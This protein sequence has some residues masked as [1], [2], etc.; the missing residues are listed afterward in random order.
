MRL[1]FAL[2]FDNKAKSD[3]M[4]YQNLLRV[5]GMDG[6]VTPKQNLHITLAFIGECTENQKQTLIDILRQL[7]SG[8]GSLRIDHLGSFRQKRSRLVWLGMANNRALTRLQKELVTALIEQGFSTESKAY[9]PH[10]TIVRRVP[11]NPQLKDIHI[12]P[13]QISVYSIAL[14]ESVY[15]ENRLVYQVIDEVIQ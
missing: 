3:L 14:M 1:F 8:C 4:T 5:H 11:G 2:T 10:I 7:K 6:R 13:R 9:I 15:Q 12:K